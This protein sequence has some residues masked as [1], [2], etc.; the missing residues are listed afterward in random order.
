MKFLIAPNS[1]P[2]VCTLGFLLGLRETVA[3]RVGPLCKCGAIRGISPLERTGPM[4]RFTKLDGVKGAVFGQAVLRTSKAQFHI[5]KSNFLLGPNRTCTTVGKTGR[6]R[7]ITKDAKFAVA[8][9]LRITR[10]AVVPLLS[11]GP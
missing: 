5:P 3:R 11:E 9:D 2:R 4:L 8:S 1:R 10:P 7:G 6:S